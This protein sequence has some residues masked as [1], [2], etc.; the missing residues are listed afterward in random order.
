MQPVLN[1]PVVSVQGKYTNGV[2]LLGIKA[3]EAAGDFLGCFVLFYI[4]G[5]ASDDK[6]LLNAG[7]IGIAVK[8]CAGPDLTSFYPTVSL[9]DTLVLRGEN[10]LDRGPRCRPARW[11]DCLWR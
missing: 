8:L 4:K 10:R 11:V 6:N 2:C 3:C 1:T 7:E 9:I 5:L